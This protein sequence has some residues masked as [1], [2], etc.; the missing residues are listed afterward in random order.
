MKCIKHGDI[1]KRVTDNVAYDLVSNA[2]AT[3]CSK[4]EWKEK[5]RDAS[6]KKFKN[7]K[8]NDN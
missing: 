1:I 3:Y 6:F 4:S 7:T 5:V 8:K 2:R